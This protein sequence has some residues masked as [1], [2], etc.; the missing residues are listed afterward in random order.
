VNNE[1]DE[2]NIEIL[3]IYFD[4]SVIIEVLIT[5]IV[6]RNLF[7]ILIEW[8]EFYIF[9]QILNRANESKITTS[10]SEIA[11]KIKKIWDKYKDAVRRAF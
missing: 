3:E 11:N 1:R 7:F 10:H 4:T 9:C 8:P 5:F 2:F 6:V